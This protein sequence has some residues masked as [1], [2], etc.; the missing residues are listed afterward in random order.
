MT[1]GTIKPV[2]V[3][4]LIYE[5]LDLHTMKVISKGERDVGA[6]DFKAKEQDSYEFTDLLDLGDGFQFV[7]SDPFVERVFTMSLNREGVS[8]FSFEGFGI[9][10]PGHANQISKSGSVAFLTTSKAQIRQV[11]FLSDIEIDATGAAT[12]AT[13]PKGTAW[14]L[15]ILRGSVLVLPTDK[16]TTASGSNKVK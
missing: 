8:T 5:I 6:S 14:R 2:S 13:A 11:Q 4:H 12:T 3:G 15:R 7:F 10:Q 16:E 1:S 9:D